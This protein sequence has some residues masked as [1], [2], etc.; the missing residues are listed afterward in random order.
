MSF[1]PPYGFNVSHDAVAANCAAASADCAPAVPPAAPAAS[2][3][4][5]TESINLHIDPLDWRGYLKGLFEPNDFIDLFMVHGSKINPDTDSAFTDDNF[6]TL[7]YFLSKDADLTKLNEEWH[8]Y[9]CMNPLIGRRRRKADVC[10]IRN[11]YIELDYDAPA[12]LE[13]MWEDVEAGVIP[14]PHYILESSPNR[15]QVVWRVEGFTLRQQ[16]ALNKTLAKRYNADLKA[17]DGTRVLR[18]IG[19]KNI[20]EH[21]NPKPVVHLTHQFCAPRLTP[22]DFKVDISVPEERTPN[23]EA[24]DKSDGYLQQACDKAHVEANPMEASNGLAYSVLCPNRHHHGSHGDYGC[25]WISPTGAFRYSC[26]HKHCTDWNWER[27]RQFLQTEAESHGFVGRLRF[28]DEQ[29][30]PF[31]TE[32]RG[33]NYNAGNAGENA[34]ADAKTNGGANNGDAKTAKL[35]TKRMSEFTKKKLNW[36]WEKRIPY[37]TSTT[38]AGE[39]DEAKS[40]I[41]LYVAACVTRGWCFHGETQPVTIGDVLLLAAEDDPETTLSPRLEAAGADLERVH[42]VESIVDKNSKFSERMTQLGNDLEALM[43]KLDEYPQIRLIILDPISSYLGNVPMNKE[44]EVRE[45]LNPFVK[46][47][48]T[49]KVAAL[50]VAHFNKNSETTSAIDRVA[51]AKAIV[52]VGRAAW[53]C[54]REPKRDDNTDYERRMFLKLKGNLTPSSVGGLIYTV[55]VK[56]IEVENDGGKEMVEVP[57]VVWL[58]K[59]DK[60]AQDVVIDGKEKTKTAT[61]MAQDWLKEYL[62]E[63]GGS[64]WF[65]NIIKDGAELGYDKR[66]LQRAGG[67]LGVKVVHIG[68]QTQ[69]VMKGGN[70]QPE[71]TAP[72]PEVRGRN[73]VKF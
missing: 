6:G 18:L 19:F 21:Y 4:A 70:Q 24:V 60:S 54:V 31:G 45:V 12:N 28:A 30:M 56:L 14:Q 46:A 61:E 32:A 55:K 39:P 47:L 27:Y 73:G 16:E 5:E 63:S 9:V 33:A 26:W 38:L 34:G 22:F 35:V 36:L 1:N 23:P 65:Q 20:K 40:L 48:R 13:K 8:I 2:L 58:E 68:K 17:T 50:F 51:G 41:S 72:E 29:S 69:W 37:G 71:D 11:V 62:G 66:T 15:Y 64:A 25:I 10:E 53:V 57:Y 59:T 44:Q 7:E 52:G 67:K 42:L 43:A 49:R 3:A